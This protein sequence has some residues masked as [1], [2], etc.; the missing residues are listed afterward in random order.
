MS[1]LRIQHSVT[2]AKPRETVFQ[3][4]V[5]PDQL[6]RYFVSRSSG[7]LEAGK[8]VVWTWEREQ[9]SDD[10][11]CVELVP[12]ERVVLAWKAYKIDYQTRFTL[13]VQDAGEGRTKVTVEETGWRRD[14]PGIDSAIEHSAGWMHM[15]LC[16]KAYLEHGIDLRG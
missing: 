8:T 1:E 4:F 16:M 7:P 3:A 2:I 5:Q 13:S 14:E 10:T 15:L 6:A 9:V 11:H 12:N